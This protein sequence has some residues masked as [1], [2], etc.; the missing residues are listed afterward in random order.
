MKARQISPILHHTRIE[1]DDGEVV[2]HI[3]LPVLGVPPDG[4]T[5]EADAFVV[6]TARTVTVRREN[7]TTVIVSDGR[8]YGMHNSPA[9]A[10]FGDLPRERGETYV[11]DIV[12]RRVPLVGPQREGENVPQITEKQVDMVMNLREIGRGLDSAESPVPPIAESPECG[13]EKEEGPFPMCREEDIIRVHPNVFIH[14][15]REDKQFQVV[16]NVGVQ[17]F[18]VGPQDDDERHARF[19]AAMLTKAVETLT[20]AAAPVPSAPPVA[21]SEGPRW[22]VPTAPALDVGEFIETVGT[23]DFRVGHYKKRPCIVRVCGPDWSIMDLPG[24]GDDGN[25]RDWVKCEPDLPIAKAFRTAYD[26]A[27]SAGQLPEHPR[28]AKPEGAEV[29]LGWFPVGESGTFDF[30]FGIEN[31]DCTLFREGESESGSC[32]MELVTTES[33]IAAAARARELNLPQRAELTKRIASLRAARD[34]ATA[35]LEAAERELR[36]MGGG[37]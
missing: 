34:T 32:A 25:A 10:I 23:D 1:S 22:K 35:D 3:Y 15:K 36:E 18:N 29:F 26:R 2:S 8:P 24:A 7:P 30:W 27:L 4:R 14:R 31:G 37:A 6:G 20:G 13:T 11:Y 28:W 17:Y 16:F 19:I 33:Y 9:E 12:R 5:V 21:E